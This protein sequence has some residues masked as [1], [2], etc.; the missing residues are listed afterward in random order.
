MKELLA[1]VAFL[2]AAI[3]LIPFVA[4]IGAKSVQP[5]KP[6][7]S[8]ITPVAVPKGV[9]SAASGTLPAAAGAFRVLDVS[10][11][12]IEQIGAYDYICGVVAAEEPAEYHPEALKAQA[13]AAFTYALYHREYNLSHPGAFTEYHG[14][15]VSTDPATCKAYISEADAK[16]EWGDDFAQEWPRIA[17]AVSAVQN[18]VILYNGKPIEAFFFDMSSGTTESSKD[19]WGEDLP[20]LQEVPSPGDTLAHGFET[21]VTMKTA[22]FR[23]KVAADYPD[24]KFTADPSKWVTT[25]RRSAAGGIITASV[26]GETFSGEKVRTL[27]G[28]RSANVRITYKNGEFL[29]DVKGYGH[30]VG[31]SQVGSEYMAAHGKNYEEILQWYYHGVKIADCSWTDI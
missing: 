25:I 2:S 18:K 27:F 20:Y 9:A 29:F 31:M 21:K 13:V 19:V 23:K 11:G 24:A 30:G 10:T 17:A 16:R 8:A 22:E 1:I 5:D 12:K 3:V 15:D 4:C 26:C 6:Q 7:Y 14:A 28:L